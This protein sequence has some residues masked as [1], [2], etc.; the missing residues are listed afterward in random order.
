M[1]RLFCFFGLLFL[2][3][4][5]TGCTTSLTVERLENEEQ[6]KVLSGPIYYLPTTKLDILVTRQLKKCET[7]YDYDQK[8]D[9]YTPKVNIEF[10]VKADVTPRYI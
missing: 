5:S 7:T 10:L 2:I 4:L 9:E 3:F 8:S 1:K 6:D